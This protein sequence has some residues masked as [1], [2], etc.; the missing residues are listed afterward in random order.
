M[1]R[2]LH[3]IKSIVMNKGQMRKKK[4]TLKQLCQTAP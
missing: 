4:Y 2:K 3:E 1:D